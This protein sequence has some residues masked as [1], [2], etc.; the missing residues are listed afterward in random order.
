MLGSR[1]ESLKEFVQQS[2]FLLS[3]EASFITGSTH[4]VDSG[5]TAP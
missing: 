1:H 5:Y 3:K 2:R 4:L